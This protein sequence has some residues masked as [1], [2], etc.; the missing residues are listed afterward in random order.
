MN[1]TYIVQSPEEAEA[2]NPQNAIE[3]TGKRN[4]QCS[5]FTNVNNNMHRII[6]HCLQLVSSL[7]PTAVQLSCALAQMSVA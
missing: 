3:M 6:V 7:P 2:C 1:N 5:M 4:T